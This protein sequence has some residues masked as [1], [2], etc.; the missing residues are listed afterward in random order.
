MADVRARVVSF[1]AV[2]IAT[3]RARRASNIEM[4]RPRIVGERGVEGLVR[5][6]QEF[7]G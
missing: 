7:D 3:A 1:N 6:S 4:N 2:G 5:V